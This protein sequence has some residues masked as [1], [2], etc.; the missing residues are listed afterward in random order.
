MKQA[1]AVWSVL[2]LCGL[3]FGGCSSTHETTKTVRAPIEQ[4]LLAESF[5]RGLSDAVLPLTSDQS[6]AV[7]TI[8]LTDDRAYA[9]GMIERWL[10]REGVRIPKDGKETILA[11]VMLDTFGTLQ[12]QTFFGIPPIASSLIPVSLPELSF[13]KASRQQGTVRF[14]IDFIERET[15]RLLRSTPVYEGDA[16]YNQYTVFF[17]ISFRETDLLPP[18]P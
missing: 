11:R 5:K 2:I 4:Q 18:P 14:S 6:V 12:D 7:E 16:F 8:G 13:Y 9:T 1:P 17:V 3:G 15:G 10:V